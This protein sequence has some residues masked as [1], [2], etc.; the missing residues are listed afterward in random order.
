MQFSRQVANAM[1]FF[2]AVAAM[3]LVSGAVTTAVAQ[4]SIRIS[5]QVVPAVTEQV[6]KAIT[7]AIEAGLRPSRLSI[8]RSRVANVNAISLSADASYLASGLS[9]GSLRLWDLRRGQQVLNLA[10]E[11]GEVLSVA[12]SPD[13]T[14][15]AT[16]GKGGA[17][18][19]WNL[20]NGTKSTAYE[21]HGGAVLTIGF[22]ADGTKV[23]T[24][25]ADQTARLWD[26]RTGQEL[27]R[28]E[29]HKGAV[30]SVVMTANGKRIFTAGADNMIRVWSGETGDSLGSVEAHRGGIRAMAI[31]SDST[32]LLTAAKDGV[33]RS[34]DLTTGKRIG[35]V[36]ELDDPVTSI[37]LSPDDTLVAVGVMDRTVR[38]YDVE[39]GEELEVFRGHSE[40]VTLVAF[41]GNGLVIHSASL[42]GTSRVWDR[43]TKAEVVKLISTDT[44]WTVINET[45]QFDGSVEG[46][47]AVQWQVEEEPYDLEQFT[48]SYYEPGLLTRAVAR[49]PIPVADLPSITNGIKL[50]PQ[51]QI[52]SPKG[53]I[54]TEEEVV[55]VAVS[56]TDQGGGVEEIRVFH[57]GKRI[58]E[59]VSRTAVYR[60]AEQ[61]EQHVKTIN[62]QLVPGENVIQAVGVSEDRIESKPVRVALTLR[63]PE[64]SA[65][66]HVLTIGVNEY[67]NP[68]LNLN[69]GV[70]DATAINDFFVATSKGLFKDVRNYTLYNENATRDGI[71]AQFALLADTAPE[72]VVIVYFAGHGETIDDGWYFLPH[73]LVYPE[74]EEEIRGKGLSSA[75]I[76]AEIQKIGAQKVLLLMDACKSG[77][78]LISF[79]GFEERKA[80]RQLARSSGIHVVA[81][82]GKDQF[83]AEVEELGH[84]VFTYAILEGLSGGADGTPNDGVVTI[85]ELLSFVESE[86][87]EISMKH[88]SQ[89]QFP[90]VDSRGQNFPLVALSDLE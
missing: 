64:R 23:M 87:P 80:L 52:L 78:A 76:Q 58:D 69:Y 29:G 15:I 11:G 34:W 51:V 84:G 83:A 38:V 44:G 63:A 10:A 53:G 74:K 73:E 90:V 31:S 6:T 86:L 75:V 27:F 71:M 56:A 17:A 32:V 45:G 42:D 55:E 3:A 89:A 16:A 37:S 33:V 41:G 14:R 48:E 4:N 68:A 39:S 54:D 40:P 22:S 70:P 49:E 26:A 61:A 36:A 47:E 2:A 60:K 88:K 66:I 12:I 50:P 46:F 7:R 79:R 82:A 43:P 20:A 30:T 77:A 65:T 19:L 35:K 85:R 21:G 1:P 67:R 72:D 13:S 28:L 81:A 18:T 24:G 57:N 5:P 8:D 9:D 62:L 25:S 59:S